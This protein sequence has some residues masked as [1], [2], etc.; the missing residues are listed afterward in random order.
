MWHFNGRVAYSLTN[1]NIMHIHYRA[2]VPSFHTKFSLGWNHT[3]FGVPAY[4]WKIELP[5]LVS[6]SEILLHTNFRVAPFGFLELETILIIQILFLL[7]PLTYCDLVIL[8]EWLA[9]VVLREMVTRENKEKPW[10]DRDRCLYVSGANIMIYVAGFSDFAFY[11]FPFLFL[12][13]ANVGYWYN[14]D[15]HLLTIFMANYFLYY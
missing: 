11:F 6:F 15:K 10:C 4:I 9:C 12:L 1:N 2:D 5:I 14:I 13:V 8:D 3:L 7:Q